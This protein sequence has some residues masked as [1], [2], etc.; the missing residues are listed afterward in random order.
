[1][2]IQ[3][4]LTEVPDSK[5]NEIVGDFESEGA[6]VT[7]TQQA[8]GNWTVTATFPDPVNA[9]TGSPAGAGSASSVAGG[10]PSQIVFGAKVS[11]EFKQK[12]IQISQELG[13]DPNHLMAAMAFETGESF[14]PSVVNSVSGATGLIQF[15]PVTAKDLGTTTE[16]MKTMTAVQQLD[17]VRKYFLRFKN[18]L[19]SI[20]DTYMA[21][22]WPKA[23]GEP[24]DFVL[25]QRGSIAYEQNSGLD[26]NG[27]GT[28]TKAE[29]AAKVVKAL[30]RGHAFAA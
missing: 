14:S 26:L 30:G 6:S 4:V 15:M 20:E 25:W 18:R 12:V 28:V 19:A 11:P 17:F 29:A 24:N 23:I 9:A 10:A 1:M 5:V 21:I 16:Q 27:D 7:K 22:L 3:R 13:L 8:N 2:S